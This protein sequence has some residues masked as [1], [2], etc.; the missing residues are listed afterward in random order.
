MAAPDAQKQPTEQDD[1]ARDHAKD[2]NVV[3]PHEV[4][5][6]WILWALWSIVL[7]FTTFVSMALLLRASQPTA[8]FRADAERLA[9][10]RRRRFCY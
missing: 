8:V 6:V 7:G 10:W 1:D 2:P 4:Y 5:P 3:Y 9:P